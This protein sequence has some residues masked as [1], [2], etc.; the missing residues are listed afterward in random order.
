MTTRQRFLKTVIFRRLKFRWYCRFVFLEKIRHIGVLGVSVRGINAYL[1][2]ALVVSLADNPDSREDDPRS[3]TSQ[4]VT[5]EHGS[6]STVAGSA[7][8]Y[9]F[10]EASRN[11]PK[12][13]S[14]VIGVTTAQHGRE[15]SGNGDDAS[16]APKMQ[17]R[18]PPSPL[19]GKKKK[20]TGEAMRE[21]GWRREGT[22]L[23]RAP[24][25][26]PVFPLALVLA[27]TLL[28]GRFSVKG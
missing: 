15:N 4:L 11:K 18:I 16:G 26:S 17:D 22:R 25:C 8:D 9:P 14:P 5:L 6:W 10:Y 21:S 13:R 2:S 24:P 27:H 3:K 1:V 19:R 23:F 12:L 20:K 28:I 7:R